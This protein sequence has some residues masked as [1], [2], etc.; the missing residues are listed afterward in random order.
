MCVMPDHGELIAVFL[1]SEI[2]NLEKPPG[3]GITHMVYVG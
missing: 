2:S 1:V 3:A